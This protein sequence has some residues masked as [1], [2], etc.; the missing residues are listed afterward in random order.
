MMNKISTLKFS[1]S[2]K[3]NHV[4]NYKTLG[5]RFAFPLWSYQFGHLNKVIFLFPPICS[6]LLSIHICMI[7]N[8]LYPLDLAWKFFESRKLMKDSEGERSSKDSRMENA[9]KQPPI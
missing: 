2:Y 1:S 8:D 6:E 9:L 5:P 4:T 7:K 3:E